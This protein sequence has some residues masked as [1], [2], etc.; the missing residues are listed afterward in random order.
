MC[1][2]LQTNDPFQAIIFLVVYVFAAQSSNIT[3]P[4]EYFQ[5]SNALA[6]SAWLLLALRAYCF[7]PPSTRSNL[8]LGHGGITVP[9]HKFDDNVTSLFSRLGN[10]TGIQQGC[11]Q[12]TRSADILFPG[13]A[14]KRKA[15]RVSSGLASF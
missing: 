11:F 9:F 10:T 8:P 5:K 3:P 12:S 4:K 6:P 2:C 14:N 15:D 7:S 1:V 13:E